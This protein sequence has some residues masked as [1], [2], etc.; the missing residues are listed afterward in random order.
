MI[1]RSALLGNIDILT[2]SEDISMDIDE[3]IASIHTNLISQRFNYVTCCS[4]TGKEVIYDILKYSQ[5]EEDDI[6]ENVEDVQEM[7]VLQ[8]NLNFNRF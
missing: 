3:G 2:Y 5:N 8:G 7:E 1:P 6:E 4:C